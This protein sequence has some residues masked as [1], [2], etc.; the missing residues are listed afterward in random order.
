MKKK[1]FK[2]YD[3]SDGFFQSS[4]APRGPKGPVRQF[5]ELWL[6]NVWT[7]IPLNVMYAML[8]VLLIPG[9]LAQAGM[10]QVT[11]DM[12]RGRHSFVAADFFETIRKNWRR[13]LPAGLLILLIWGFMLFVGWF[14]YTSSGLIATMGLGCCLTAMFFV[15][16]AEHYVWIQLVLLK[17]PLKKAFKNACLLVFVDWKKN[18][19]LGLVRLGYFAAMLGIFLLLPYTVTPALLLVVTVCFYPG[20]MQLLTQ[21]C[22]FPGVRSN[23]IDPYYEAH[24]EEDLEKRKDLGLL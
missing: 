9:G 8:R 2:R 4:R 7:L 13:A 5:L 3:H 1:K 11:L 12:S 18:L 17:L 6:E 19:L 21:Y 15:S 24:P 22:A 14:Y 20:F 10:T 16:L 23:L